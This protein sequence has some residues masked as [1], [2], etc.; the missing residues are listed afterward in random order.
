MGE[1]RAEKLASK[2]KKIL[3]RREENAMKIIKKSFG[4]QLVAI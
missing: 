2:K 4:L 1:S 3:V